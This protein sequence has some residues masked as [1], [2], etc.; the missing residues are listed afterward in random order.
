M[1]TC[2]AAWAAG[3]FDGEGSVVERNGWLALQLKMVD[4]PTVARFAIAVGTPDRVLG[5]YKNRS[6]ERDGYPRRDF[7]VWTTRV[8]ET[9]RILNLLWPWLSEVRRARALELGFVPRTN[10]VESSA[11]QAGV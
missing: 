3:L 9:F 1:D 7:Y 5:P 6:G 11:S 4:R 10:H 8:G 2:E